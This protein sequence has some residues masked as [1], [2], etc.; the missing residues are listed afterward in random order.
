MPLIITAATPVKP[1]SGSVLGR[2][3][4]EG[5]QRTSR[6]V[7]VYFWKATQALLSA[8]PSPMVDSNFNL[9]CS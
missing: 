1:V 2:K 8:G 6:R 7:F 3:T 5:P 9:C 4:M